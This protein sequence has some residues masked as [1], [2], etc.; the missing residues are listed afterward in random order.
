MPV[1]I[2]RK[3]G[4]GRADHVGSLLRPKELAAA[5]EKAAARQMPADE[6]KHIEDRLILRAMR[7]QEEI[8]LA[9][10]TDGE[11]RR[12]YWHFDFLGRLGGMRLDPVAPTSEQTAAFVQRHKL[13]VA[14]P[15]RWKDHPFLDHIRFVV[16]N[17]KKT[18]RLTIPAPTY[19]HF[20]A[21]QDA[22]ASGVYPDLDR[23]H[24]DLSRTYADGVAAIA[25]TGCRYLQ[26]DEV[27]LAMICDPAQVAQAKE[28]GIWR[29]DLAKVYV[30]VI[31]GAI[32]NRPADMRIGLHL[33]RGNFQSTFA[34]SGGYEP[35]AEA[36]FNACSVDTYFLEFDTERA[37]GFEPLRHLP[38]GDKTVVLGLVTSKTGTIETKDALKRRIEEAARFA[39]DRA[40]GAQP[41]VRLRLHRGRQQARRGRAVGQA[42]VVR[43][44]CQGGL[45]LTR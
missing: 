19:I 22:K 43:G 14:G 40:T 1:D 21:G 17:T 34:A 31:E 7:R 42:Q 25:A 27:N 9:S 44:R 26:I 38:K 39:P 30:D 15:L 8:G 37:G 10:I 45:G 29:D 2:A 35:V 33:C 4:F 36:L 32:K 5:K 16:A 6:L 28:R 13:V 41:A 3:P 11:Y 18:A 24:E 23:M 20:R 12:T